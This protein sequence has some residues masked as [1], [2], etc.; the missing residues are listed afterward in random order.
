VI[1]YQVPLGRDPL[2]GL[3][4]GFLEDVD[5]S[6]GYVQ[7]ERWP[8]LPLSAPPPAHDIDIDAA[9]YLVHLEREQR[10]LVE[11][12]PPDVRVRNVSY[13]PEGGGLGWHTNSALPGWRVYVP[14]LPDAPRSGTRTESGWFPD[15]PGFANMFRITDWRN[16]WHCVEAHTARLSAGLWID[17]TRAA[18]L[19][20]KDQQ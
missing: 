5:A 15:R 17:D 1:I 4:A 7:R 14:L 9:R 12:V 2:L 6:R 18:T 20:G 13:Y 11:L 10:A 8:G 19:I 16:S 3:L